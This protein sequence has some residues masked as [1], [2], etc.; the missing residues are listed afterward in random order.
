L[1]HQRASKGMYLGTRYKKAVFIGKSRSR[2][3]GEKGKQWSVI[4]M[5]DKNKCLLNDKETGKEKKR[6]CLTQ[7]YE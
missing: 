4:Y 3:K 6:N 7:D 2:R 1:V 5:F